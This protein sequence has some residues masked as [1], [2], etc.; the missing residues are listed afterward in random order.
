MR[1]VTAVLA[2]AVLVS[3]TGPDRG[4]A[5]AGPVATAP[6]TAARVVRYLALGDSYTAGQGLAPFDTAT[7]GC[8]RSEVAFP[9]LVKA[10]TSTVVT[11]RACTGATTDNVVEIEQH[12]GVGLQIAGV[13]PEVDLVSITIGGNDLGFGAVMSECVYSSL[14]CSRLDDRVER[15][16]SGLGPRLERIYRDVRTRAPGARLVV[17]GYPQLIADPDRVGGGIDIGS[18]PTLVGPFSGGL[19][20]DGDEVRWLRAKGDRLAGV[21]RAATTAVGAAYVDSAAAFAG[22]EACAPEP[23]VAGVAVPQVALSFHPNAA[24]HA[25]LARLVSRQAGE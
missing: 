13:T 16:L 23:W 19:R 17:V 8:H 15:A 2:A 6:T 1:R 14:P 7:P 4:G 11:S 3:C 21:I 24:G 9:R 5:P 18:C 22:H 10:G 12:P 25:E 20:V